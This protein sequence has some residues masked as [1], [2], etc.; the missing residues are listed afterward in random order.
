M[1]KRGQVEHIF[2]MA[3]LNLKPSLFTP[4]PPCTELPSYQISII[5]LLR[6]TVFCATKRNE[7]KRNETKRNGEFKGTVCLN[8]KNHFFAMKRT[9]GQF[10]QVK[11]MRRRITRVFRHYNHSRRQK[12]NI[13]ISWHSVTKK[14]Y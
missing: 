5:L 2:T 6:L 3:N 9:I 4:P 8:V 10:L 13:L 7:T 11:G 12:E 1:F 14:K